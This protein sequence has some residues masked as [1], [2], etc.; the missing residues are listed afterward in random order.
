MGA[1]RGARP[2]CAGMGSCAGTCDGS[3]RTACAYPGSGVECRA[4]SCADGVATNRGTCD[5]AGLCGTATTTQCRPYT[6][7][8][9]QCRSS[10]TTAADCVDGN[11]CEMGRC[12]PRAGLGTPCSNTAQCGADAVC[13]DG[14]CCNR[15]CDGVCESCALPAT[16]GVCTPLPANTQVSD[17]GVPGVCICNGTSGNCTTQDAGPPPEDAAVPMDAAPIVAYRGGGCG[18]STPGRSDRASV[19]GVLALAA[20]A[21]GLRRRRR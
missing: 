6:C 16:A 5:G 3:S 11:R 14:V 19:L 2:A 20:A 9:A 18:C 13:S 17:A 7:D 21:A 10:C 12:V 1:P 15:A 4:A 8:G